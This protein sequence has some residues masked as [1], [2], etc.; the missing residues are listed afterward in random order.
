MSEL[1]R[2]CISYFSAPRHYFW[3]W[4]ENGTVAEF[5]NGRT[6][7]YREDLV[8]LLS[9]L[10]LKQAPPLGAV[11]LVL[12][13]CKDGYEG[14]FELETQLY[15]LGY[16]KDYNEG[17][18]IA[19]KELIR[20]AIM[21]LKLVNALPVND[22]T[23]IKRIELLQ[24]VFHEDTEVAGDDELKM[25]VNAFA[26]GQQDDSIFGRQDPYNFRR[27]QADLAPLGAALARYRNTEMLHNWLR[28]GM[29]APPEKPEIDIPEEP[30]DLMAELNADVKT[31]GLARV[32]RQVLA[33]LNIPM[34]FNSGG[35][36]EFGG[37]A[38]ITNRGD[39]DKL[40]LSE[41]A[42]D[43][44]SL[45]ARLANNEALFLQ[46]ERLPTHTPTQW[47]VL[48][49][50]TLK[51][52]GTPRVFALAAALAFS[53]GKR[54]EQLQ[55]WT[56]GQS[57]PEMIDL[58]SKPGILKALEKIDA[59]LHCGIALKKVMASQIDERDHFLLIT[60]ADDQPER[61][62]LMAL[63]GI[64][65]RLDY[66]IEVDRDGHIKM[67][68]TRGQHRRLL[69]TALID[70][71]YLVH[72]GAPH[73]RPEVVNNDSLPAMMQLEQ[74]PL[75]FPAS[76]IKV[77]PQKAFKTSEEGAV[78][79]TM[80]ERLL[81]WKDQEHGAI[82]LVKQL[83]IDGTNFWGTGTGECAGFIYLI[84]Q[85]QQKK[86]TVIYTADTHD[87][88]YMQH[89]LG[90]L[91]PN[92]RGFSNNL[93]YGWLN[94]HQIAINPHRG[95]HEIIDRS[96][97]YAY[98]NAPRTGMQKVKQMVY[99][100]YSVINSAK[101]IK[102]VGGNKL[103]IDQYELV[104]DDRQNNALY[105]ATRRPDQPGIESKAESFIVKTMQNVKFAR[106]RWRDG[107]EIVLDSRGF[108][109]LK[110]GHAEVP[111][112]TIVLAVSKP[113]ACW[114]A[115]GKVCGSPYFIRDGKSQVISEADFYNQYILKFIQS[116]Q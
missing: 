69:T 70:M 27:L 35:N 34:H 23:G 91:M 32:A 86:R 59:G 13:A 75:Y 88:T 38:D 81:F 60:I 112:I 39:Y 66:R 67:Y 72:K 26:T 5:A 63:D 71:N 31:E 57:D 65:D 62:F 48:I 58:R 83:V 78:V 11:L 103:F 3:Q 79:I 105:W 96:P 68:E 4:T 97:A 17:E 18:H 106:Y 47:H 9:N 22:H 37:I 49:D 19:A 110:N 107:S 40:L 24:A 12:C 73:K 51:T 2:K 89:D 108:L 113:V 109:Y 56:L 33:A 80:D 116:L 41:L 1:T 90:D 50:T 100:G 14:L 82:E 76:K 87:N 61:A 43:D 53:E 36:N 52:W 6:I 74:Q 42:Q 98:I 46:R 16:D 84:I 115:D 29:L 8:F 7:C 30:A 44:V 85:N 15:K 77:K 94:S 64:R 92:I 20:S 111:E 99:G 93:F 114:S 28:T 95:T 45:M 54:S 104:L 10:Q 102:T 101:I 25:L 55:G 21:F